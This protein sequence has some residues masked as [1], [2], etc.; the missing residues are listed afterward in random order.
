[1]QLTRKP[2]SGSETG[3]VYRK[4]TKSKKHWRRYWWTTQGGIT[5]EHRR[6]RRKVEQTDKDMGESKHCI[7][8][9]IIEAIG[10]QAE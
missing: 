9:H 4:T 3:P 1:M 5:G 8:T 7:R 6:T 2:E 10:V